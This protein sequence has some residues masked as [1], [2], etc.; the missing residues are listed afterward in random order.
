MFTARKLI[1]Q[2][3]KKT[4]FPLGIALYRNPISIA[5][6]NILIRRASINQIRN[7]KSK[8][9]F[10]DVPFIIPRYFAVNVTLR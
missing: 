9:T 7:L 1:D 4:A 3:K 8:N 2:Y 5:I 10:A 6:R